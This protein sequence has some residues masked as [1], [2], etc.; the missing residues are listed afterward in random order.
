ME[1]KKTTVNKKRKTKVKSN[2]KVLPSVRIPDST[3]DLPET[4]AAIVLDADNTVKVYVSSKNQSDNTYQPNE[5]LAIA[6]A[7]LLQNEVYVETTLKT[8]RD[9]F[10]VAIQ[11]ENE[12]ANGID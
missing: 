9:L 1:V 2:K 6:I 11:K 3:I 8:F 7:S 10:E 4:S 5:E 12:P